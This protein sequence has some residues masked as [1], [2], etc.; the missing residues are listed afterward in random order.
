MIKYIVSRA[1]LDPLTPPEEGGDCGTHDQ[2]PPP[3][4]LFFSLSPLF[5]KVVV[6]VVV[7]LRGRGIDGIQAGAA[8]LMQYWGIL[9]EMR[10]LLCVCGWSEAAREGWRAYVCACARATDLC[11]TPVLM[12]S[13]QS[14]SPWCDVVTDAPHTPKKKPP[15]SMRVTSSKEKNLACVKRQL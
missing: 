2:T 3:T 12:E 11:V 10:A 1:V 9:R 5:I 8:G 7:A 15:Q 4:P 6:V 14:P 13:C